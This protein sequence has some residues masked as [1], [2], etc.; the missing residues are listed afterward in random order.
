[1]DFLV[2]EYQEVDGTLG[3]PNLTGQ[4]GT[5]PIHPQPHPT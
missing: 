4:Y 3:M 2:R 5:I 1:M